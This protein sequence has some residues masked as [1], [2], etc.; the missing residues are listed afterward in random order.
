MSSRALGKALVAWP[1]KESIRKNLSVTMIQHL[2]DIIL[3]CAALC[4]LKP[5]TYK[6][7]RKEFTEITRNFHYKLPDKKFQKME[8]W[9]G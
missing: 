5:K 1:P 9:Y 4:N 7:Q 3:T 8:F 2:D 6:N